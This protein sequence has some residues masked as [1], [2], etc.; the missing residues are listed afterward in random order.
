M[1]KK[2]PKSKTRQ[3]SQTA[4]STALV[5]AV[6]MI[7]VIYVPQSTG[8]FNL[9]EAMVYISAILF[10]PIVGSF[11]GG[12]GSMLADLLLG[13]W[14]FAPATLVGKFL[15][16]GI[17]GFLSHNKPKPP[18]RRLWKALTIII[19]ITVGIILS[20]TGPSLI[21]SLP[22]VFWYVLGG[23]AAFLIA[24]TGFIL[25]PE[26]GW[27]VLSILLGGSVMVLTYYIWEAFLILPLF[28][29]PVIAIA[30]IP[31]NIGQMAMGLIIAVPI[32]KIVLRSIP[33]LKNENHEQ[34]GELQ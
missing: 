18:S 26:L 5:T 31:V 12:V 16:G 30:E 15:E 7:F 14:E 3:L 8:F 17:V 19:G 22:L 27:L 34:K 13:F 11:A 29:T 4:I 23:L 28:G 2:T 10:G 9:G 33:L 24:I 1:A 32:T 6:T 21:S 25:E 20:A